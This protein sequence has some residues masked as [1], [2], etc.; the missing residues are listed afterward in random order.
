MNLQIKTAIEGLGA[1]KSEK[2]II[3]AGKCIGVLAAVLEEYDNEAGI[4]TPSKKHAKRSFLKDLQKVTQELLAC[5]AFDK[6]TKKVHKS[7]PKLKA[8]L[9]RKIK[10]KKLKSWISENTTLLS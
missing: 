2:A 4:D 5:D 10:E 8:N 9:I 3:R 7:F 1:N 6:T